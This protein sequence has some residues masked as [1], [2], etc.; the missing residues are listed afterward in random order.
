M[1]MGR[2]SQSYAI[3]RWTLKVHRSR[4]FSV[5]L[6]STHA[7]HI[8]IFYYQCSKLLEVTAIIYSK[9]L[10][11]QSTMNIVCTWQYIALGGH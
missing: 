4:I 6:I 5:L 2:P 3:F 9:V 1:V 7:S 11:D 8:A 10:Y